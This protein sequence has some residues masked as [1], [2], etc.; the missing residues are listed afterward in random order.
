MLFVAGAQAAGKAAKG[1]GR[2]RRRAVAAKKE[3]HKGCRASQP[4]AEPAGKTKKRKGSMERAVKAKKERRSREDA[5][6][7]RSASGGRGQEKRKCKR[8][9]GR[10]KQGGS[11]G[12]SEELSLSSEEQSAA[13][14]TGRDTGGSSSE[15]VSSSSDSSSRSERRKV[16]RRKGSGM[17]D[18][19]NE[20]WPLDTRPRLLQDRK[21]VERMSIAE[22]SQFKEH[23]EKEEEK[24]G[25]GSA[26]YGKDRKLKP[27]SFR[28]SKD[29]G[30]TKLHAARFQLRMPLCAPKKYWHKMPARR[31]VYRHFPLAHL[32]MEGQVSEATVVRMHDRRVPITLD[33]LYKGNAGR[34]SKAEKADW[35]EPTEVRHLQEAILNYVT[36]LNAL[37]PV[38]YAGLVLM[39]VLV[40]ANWGAAAGGNEKSRVALVRKFFDETVRDNSGRAVRDEP[41]LTYEEA[42]A[43]WIR[44]MESMLPGLGVLGMSVTTLAGVKLKQQ[45]GQ[46]QQQQ[47]QQ[48]NRG[49][50]TGGGGRGAARGGRGGGSAVGGGTTGPQRSGAVASGLPVCYQFNLP[51]GCSR[52]VASANACKDAKG[53]HFAHACNWLDKQTNK[54]CLQLHARCTNH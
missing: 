20:M 5:S 13:E 1:E 26:V 21:T 23:Y 49:G 46:Q 31:E 44:V 3:E 27:V 36:L 38:D 15:S 9:K 12:S 40:E 35:L 24:K 11:R 25:A 30:L 52:D 6:K 41:P 29:D 39:R 53:A 51:H 45:P 7:G 14:S 47:K 34:D 19:V 54:F 8:G 16:K 42:K 2:S 37:W 32:G 22:I 28:K 50:G 43:K 17:W 4:G 48:A 10:K 33:M 18:L